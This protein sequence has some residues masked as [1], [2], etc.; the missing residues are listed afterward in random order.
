[1]TPPLLLPSITTYVD[2]RSLP[3]AP[4]DLQMP[5][6]AW[7]RLPRPL[8]LCGGDCGCAPGWMSTCHCLCLWLAWERGVLGELV[9]TGVRPR[10]KSKDL[11]P[12][13][14]RAP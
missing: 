8:W 12:A 13:P 14:C 10:K 6:S 2:A 1:M 7:C 3:R 11:R 9:G 5:T 4:G